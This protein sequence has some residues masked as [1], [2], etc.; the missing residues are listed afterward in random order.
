MLNRVLFPFLFINI[1]ITAQQ[2]Q[3]QNTYGP[4]EV[5]VTCITTHPSGYLF[6]GTV[7]HYLY[8]SSDAGE[9]WENITTGFLSGHLSDV[10]VRI[11]E[12]IFISGYGI[13]SS[14]DLGNSWNVMGPSEH[15]RCIVTNSNGHI[16]AG[17]WH[18][19]YR[20]T[21]NGITWEG[22]SQGLPVAWIEEI[23]VDSNDNL[24]AGTS[25][26]IYRS[27][28]S[29]VT[30]IHIGKPEWQVNGLLFEGLSM[31]SNGWIFTLE[32]NEGIYY[33]T[34]VGTTWINANPG[35][36]YLIA[37][38]LDPTD[39]RLLVGT[40]EGHVYQSIDLGISWKRINENYNF[41]P[42]YTF[43]LE[44]YNR[45]IVGTEY[46]GVF[47]TTDYGS[48]W[49]QKNA[50]FK[51]AT[52]YDLESNSLGDI[53]ARTRTF[54]YRSTDNGTQWMP[55]YFGDDA[56]ADIFINSND[57]IFAST[58]FLPGARSTDFG[59][60]WTSLYNGIC[61]Y[62]ASWGED[63][64]QNIYATASGFYMSTN[65]GNYW[66]QI[67]SPYG[68]QTFEFYT[69]SIIIGGTIFGTILRSTD[70]GVSWDSVGTSGFFKALSKT[71][72][73]E[74]GTIFLTSPDRGGI[75]RSVD[76]GNSWVQ[77]TSDISDSSIWSIT[78]DLNGFIYIATHSD[79][80]FK[81]TNNGDSW[82][83]INSEL[84][85][86]TVLALAVNKEGYLFAGYAENGIYRTVLPT[87][88]IIKEH[89]LPYNYLLYQNYPNPFNPTTAIKYQIP[90]L[91]FVTIKVYDVLGGEVATVISE[92]KPLGNYEVEF[93]AATLP[94]GVYFYRLQAGS[95]VEAKKMV[96]LK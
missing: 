94:S 72:I 2:I 57:H 48:N 93:N 38:G 31:N 16:F 77:L 27:T 9:N 83:S 7:S 33:S 41:S 28:D 52:V 17:G 15:L 68:L 8:R 19:I 79:G 49:S 60:T 43:N 76:G 80:I 25:F 44:Y 61:C 36:P 85:D 12:D 53:F 58:S 88:T 51:Q 39:N 32:M 40:L 64:N 13:Y 78:E 74:N 14:T 84:P 92:E 47:S 63:F 69:Q 89:E 45:V 56:E 11:N 5:G 82:A 26:G 67:S 81:S 55:T 50:G 24:I 75:H 65:N 10:Y 91:S 96:L 90:E 1:L 59:N 54:I 86:T 18:I 71:I 42:V 35:V 46:A 34:D 3:W 66:T 37:L 87:T 23:L 22:I 21:N 30:W 70:T 6:A 95:F 73:A 20:S 29:G 4:T 62:I